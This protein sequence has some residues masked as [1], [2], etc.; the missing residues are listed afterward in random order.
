MPV[1]WKL[2]SSKSCDFTLPLFIQV[3][4]VLGAF[5]ALL[6]HLPAVAVSVNSVYL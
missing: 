3:L 5:I 2:V 6:P 4:D 1:L